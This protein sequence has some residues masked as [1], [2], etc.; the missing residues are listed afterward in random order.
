MPVVIILHG[1][2]TLPDQLQLGSERHTYLQFNILKTQLVQLP[3]SDYLDSRNL[4]AR[5]NLPNMN[6][7]NTDKVETYA[8]AME[9]LV[10]LE[11]DIEK[12]LKYIDFVDIYSNLNP[13]ELLDYQ[14]H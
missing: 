13:Q 14:H 3:A 7:R 10:T 5:L 2:Q 12:Q 11:P 8:K 6:H 9:G 4:V 1:Q